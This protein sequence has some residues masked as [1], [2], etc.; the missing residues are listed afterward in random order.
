MRRV[1]AVALLAVV[2]ACG[3]GSHP[4]ATPTKAAAASPASAARTDV[5]PAPTQRASGPNL[6]S[7]SAVPISGKPLADGYYFGFIKAI[8]LK[9]DVARIDFAQWYSCKCTDDYNIRD[10]S[11]KIWTVPVDPHATVTVFRGAPGQLYG[12][13]RYLA[14]SMSLSRRQAA[15]S[16]YRGRYGVYWLRIRSGRIVRIDDVFTP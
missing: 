14:A 12:Q 4:A 7:R 9:R 3:S 2:T 15:S 13:L 5:F 1:Y 16:A 11:K 6:P 10:A 8:D